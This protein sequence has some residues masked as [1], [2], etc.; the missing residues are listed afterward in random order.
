M[1]ATVAYVCQGGCGKFT[2]DV[3]ELTELGMVNKKLYCDECAVVV[4]S[5]LEMRDAL[6]TDLATR[7]SNG[8]ASL[9]VDFL[10][11]VKNLP[12]GG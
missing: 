12:D 8:L 3:S 5:Y 9:Q 1:P 4:G 6:H 10:K 7:W 2:E 11:R